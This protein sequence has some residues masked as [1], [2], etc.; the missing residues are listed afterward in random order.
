MEGYLSRHEGSQVNLESQFLTG[1]LALAPLSHVNNLQ[2]HSWRVG[3]V[4]A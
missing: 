3:G 4:F 1:T 2:Y